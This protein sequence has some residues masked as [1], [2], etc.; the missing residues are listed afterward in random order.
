D[1]L[2]AARWPAAPWRAAPQD[3]RDLAEDADPDAA[4]AGV[5]RAR[6]ADRSR[7]RPAA[8]R[9]RADTARRDADRPAHRDLPV[10]H[11]SPPRAPDGPGHVGAQGLSREAIQIVTPAWYIRDT[12]ERR[13][14]VSVVLVLAGPWR[15]PA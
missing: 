1:R 3:R 4:F 13:W 9:I 2:R 15:W 8:R 7:R 6:V 5:R 12:R 11:G 14:S 10:G